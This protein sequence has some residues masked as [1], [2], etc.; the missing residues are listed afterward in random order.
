MCDVRRPG[1]DAAQAGPLG[2]HPEARPFGGFAALSGAAG[3]AGHPYVL[4]KCVDFR[5]NYP[6][7]WGE[8][9]ILVS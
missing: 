6:K 4:N 1:L 8:R 7:G 5:E 2:V 3:E 9:G